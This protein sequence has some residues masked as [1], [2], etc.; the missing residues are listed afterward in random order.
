MAG[1]NYATS[2]SYDLDDRATEV[3]YGDSAHRVRYGYDGQGR[4][5]TRRVTNGNSDQTSAYSYLCNLQGDVI[6]CDL[7][8]RPHPR[9]A[10]LRKYCS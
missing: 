4:L 5:Q 6:G 9:E 8:E 7:P 2:Y 1:A 3:C 10:V